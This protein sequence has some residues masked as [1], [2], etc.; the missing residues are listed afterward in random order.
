MFVSKAF[1]G[2]SDGWAKL[3]KITLDRPATICYKVR[4]ACR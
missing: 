3:S 4:L 2:F 1:T